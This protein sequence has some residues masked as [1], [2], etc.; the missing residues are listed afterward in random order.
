M[1]SDPQVRAAAYANLGGVYFTLKE[2]ARAKENFE[3]ALNLNSRS[4]FIFLH[5]GLLAQKESDWNSA[6]RYYAI[7]VAVEPTA[8]GYFLLGQALEHSGD[9]DR[10]KRAHEQAQRS[11]RDID[12]TR[13]AAAKLLAE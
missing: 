2:Y 10:A 4:P 13:K 7:Y 8:I 1:A 9:R 3:T 12:Q 11:S 5:M 6:V